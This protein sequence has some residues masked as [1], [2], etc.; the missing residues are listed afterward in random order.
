MG[1]Y[2]SAVAQFDSALIYY[3]KALKIRPDFTVSKY[4]KSLMLEKLGKK[5]QAIA[6]YREIIE[7]DP[8]SNYADQAKERLEELGN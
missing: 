2:F 3:E 5:D 4:N 8:E 7:Q 6:V 1:D